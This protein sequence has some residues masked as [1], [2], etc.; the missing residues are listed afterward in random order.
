MKR[1]RR[2]WRGV[3]IEKGFFELPCKRYAK[4]LHPVLLPP[5]PVS[6]ISSS[7]LDQLLCYLLSRDQ[8]YYARTLDDTAAAAQ[9]IMT[10][11]EAKVGN[12][13]ALRLKLKSSIGQYSGPYTMN[14][15]GGSARDMQ[16]PSTG[17]FD[18]TDF[19][20]HRFDD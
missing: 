5:H 17:V 20:S 7:V 10:E 16:L 9:T 14:M 19:K 4:I 2:A 3:W 8:A 18:C 13:S 12:I 15:T 6:R 11:R 1:T